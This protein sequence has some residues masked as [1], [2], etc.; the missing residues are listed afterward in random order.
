MAELITYPT[1]IMEDRYGGAYSGA[2]WT[3]WPMYPEEI[4]E[5]PDDGDPECWTFWQEYKGTV[6][7]GKTPD[8][9]YTSLIMHLQALE[10]MP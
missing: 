5:G 7:K 8:E 9:A 1:T 4:P 3:A 2:A 6:G 10:A